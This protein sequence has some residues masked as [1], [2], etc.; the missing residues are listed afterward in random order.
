M[1]H[2][3]NKRHGATCPLCRVKI[4][5]NKLKDKTFAGYS[6]KSQTAA[7]KPEP[8]EIKL[9][10]AFDLQPIVEAPEPVVI[11]LEEIKVDAV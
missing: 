7:P 4:D 11:E 8:E 2:Q 10:E 5:S 3:Q 1:D 6:N 9:E